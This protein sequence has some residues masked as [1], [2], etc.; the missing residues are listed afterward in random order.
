M[1]TGIFGSYVYGDLDESSEIDMLV[2]FSEPIG[3]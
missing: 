1:K 3:W 2:E